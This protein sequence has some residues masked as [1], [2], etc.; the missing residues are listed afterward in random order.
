MNK[1][2]F[3]GGTGRSGTSVL[4]N[5]LRS[6]KD[7]FAF[8]NE[9]RFLID[10]NGLINLVDALTINYS[11]SQSRD[12]L[13]YFEEL[14]KKHFTNKYTA[15]YVG[16]EFQKFF[17]EEYYWKRLD[18]FLDDLTVGSF[19]GSDYT[20]FGNFFEQKFA[21][22]IRKFERYYKAYYRKI[23]K[24]RRETNLWP[25]REMK[26]VR[27]FADRDELCR[28][29]ESFVNDLFTYVAKRENKSIWCEKTPLNLLHLDFLYE[30]F[31][32]CHFIHIK[33]D[34]RG[35]IQS[36]QNQFWANPDIEGICKQMKQVYHRWFYLQ[37]K[38]NFEKHNYYEIKLED[39]AND[40]E[41][42]I[43]E[44]TNFISIE[45]EFISPPK[46]LLEKVNYWQKSMPKKDIE[47][48]NSILGE[49][50]EKMGYDI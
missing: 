31:P 25:R 50:I 23:L 48:V 15:P 37:R 39:L 27:F 41:N 24:Q 45:N 14:M 33:R 35:V 5:L 29:V 8:N 22:L 44:I 43:R 46:L 3:I 30:V 20:V 18:K 16:F 21:F 2:V 38:V 1:Q 34:P 26:N 42:K 28:I 13:F 47:I 9:M 11:I 32:N 19:Y 6:H 12:A 17:G 40:Y 7:I 10:H 49:E 36:M 4:Y